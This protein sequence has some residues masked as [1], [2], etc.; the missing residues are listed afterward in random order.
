MTQIHKLN[1]N[2]FHSLFSD[3]YLIQL[4]L[5]NVASQLGKAVF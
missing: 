1:R 5:I 2:D 3:I 4:Y